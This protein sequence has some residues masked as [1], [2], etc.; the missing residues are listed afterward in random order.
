MRQIITASITH[1]KG[2]HVALRL[3][4]ATVLALSS[5]LLAA[6]AWAD[7]SG[8]QVTTFATGNTSRVSG[9]DRYGTAAAT[10]QGRPVGGTVIVAGG[11]DY[12]DAL[13]ANGLAGTV[14]A[15][16]LLSEAGTLSAA[17]AT[18]LS[19]LAPE[20]VYIVGGPG[21]ISATVEN[22]IKALL[23]DVTVTR[24]GGTDRY[25][26]AYLIAE[27]AVANGASAD[28]VLVASGENYADALSAGP[29]AVGQKVPILL[30]EAAGLNAHTASFLSDHATQNAVI[31][32]GTG[33]VGPTAEATLKGLVSGEVIRLA[34][35]D[36]YATNKVVATTL[37]QRYG[38]NQVFS[39]GVASGE[40][41]PDAL[42]GGAY[43]GAQGGI[44]IIIPA[45]DDAAE[46]AQRVIDAV[47]GDHA[48]RITIIGGTGS[49]GEDVTEDI[50]ATNPV[51]AWDDPLRVE[52]NDGA[53]IDITED[54]KL[55]LHG[56]SHTPSISELEGCLR[57]SD[58]FGDGRL[59]WRGSPL[60]SSKQGYEA[61]FSLNL[62]DADLLGLCYNDPELLPY[63][64][65][66]IFEG[67]DNYFRLYGDG[68]RIPA[69]QG[70]PG[71][72]ELDRSM[73]NFI[74]E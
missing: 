49:V 65:R 61:L 67:I 20:T 35:D 46:I 36:R 16:V 57:K 23:P 7:E 59:I 17:T 18:R 52:L 63:F 39:V 74:I 44:L 30:T 14:D 56:G 6:P 15:P 27:E 33:S 40:D 22:A 28:E 19:A 8:G 50:G 73:P 62:A 9:D 21:A 5:L 43:I 3:L 1:T 37:T 32:G 42:A 47:K 29:F 12:P 24:L 69:Y 64:K 58:P 38:M 26:T 34:G 66:D 70:T 71:W 45:G 4:L 55:V 54:K 11:E 2:A 10:A 25:A 51:P 68:R 48:V 53:Y 41:Y 13:A 60:D 31:V 72:W